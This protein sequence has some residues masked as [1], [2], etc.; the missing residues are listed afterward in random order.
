[1]S[2]QEMEDHAVSQIHP[3]TFEEIAQTC[4]VDNVQAQVSRLLLK[5][6]KAQQLLDP[7]FTQ[8]S[9]TREQFV[10]DVLM[11]INLD[12]MDAYTDVCTAVYVEKRRKQFTAINQEVVHQLAA[13]QSVA[14]LSDIH[15]FAY[16]SEAQPT[17]IA[18]VT[19]P[20]ASKSGR[21]DSM[22]NASRDAGDHSHLQGG[23][24]AAFPDRSPSTTLAAPSYVKAAEKLH[25]RQLAAV[26]RG[27]AF[28][29]V[30]ETG[31]PYR[32]MTGTPQRAED[33]ASNSARTRTA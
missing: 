29:Q 13:L 10:N 11:K 22:V 8:K 17:Y 19:A 33:Y 32:D 24:K 9:M 6:N 18:L 1:M 2:Q 3:L 12:E 25:R 27:G 28:G 14:L 21:G 7:D 15:D 16:P 20:E 30:S 31:L 26:R 4:I 23:C 5:A